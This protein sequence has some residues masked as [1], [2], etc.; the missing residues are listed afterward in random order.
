LSHP[1]RIRLV[2]PWRV[3]RSAG[4]RAAG[5][6]FILLVTVTSG[7][8]D[9]IGGVPPASRENLARYAL[10]LGLGASTQGWSPGVP[11]RVVE[12]QT[13]GL[14]AWRV[15]AA[16]SV[17]SRTLIGV[18]ISRPFRRTMAQKEML[19]VN[20]ESRA[21]VEEQLGYLDLL[22]WLAATP[23]LRAGE[24]SWLDRI[25]GARIVVRRDLYHGRTVSLT[26]FTY[27]RGNAAIA[28]GTIDPEHPDLVEFKA[29]ANLDFRTT[30]RDLRVLFPVWFALGARSNYLHFGYFQSRWEKPAEHPVATLKEDPVLQDVA[31]RAAG[32]TLSWEQGLRDP[33]LGFRCGLDFAAFERRI[34]APLGYEYFI[35]DEDRIRYF[36][37][38]LEVRLNF[39]AGDE[40]SAVQA[41]C[42]ARV[43]GRQWS[44]R[45]GLWPDPEA[46]KNYTPPSDT[47]S[48]QTILERDW[49]FQL[50]AQFDL[51][52]RL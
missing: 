9:E 22:S 40:T 10:R 31:L 48:G 52:W 43:D 16:L 28:A 6:F 33:G 26:D 21:L 12:Y 32:L 14:Q 41:A 51:D 1:S 7:L 4:P 29:G 27:L 17:D 39:A 50:F 35:R 11:E 42:G 23:R 19:A 44:V 46:G 8:A 34:D 47:D 13:E 45:G 15:T 18:G 20:T 36:A 38:R 3:L 37:L 30:F 25:L 5:A 24:D 49:L 2:I